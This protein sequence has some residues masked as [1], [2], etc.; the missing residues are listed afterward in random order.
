MERYSF[1]LHGNLQSHASSEIRPWP[2]GGD[3]S[4]DGDGDD[5]GGASSEDGVDLGTQKECSPR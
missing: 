1:P 2:G 3:D 5:D 4:D